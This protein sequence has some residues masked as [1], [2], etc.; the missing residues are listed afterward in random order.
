M[1]FNEGIFQ[2]TPC[3]NSQCINVF[4]MVSH[5]KTELYP[6]FKINQG[7]YRI[8]VPSKYFDA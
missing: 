1:G 6:H 4:V 3:D 8:S 2:F 7:P 5:E